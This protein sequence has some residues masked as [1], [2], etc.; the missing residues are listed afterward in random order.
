M[1]Y[2]TVKTKF[3]VKLTYRKQFELQA[4]RVLVACNNVALFMSL[5]F[6]TPFTWLVLQ[7]RH[8]LF[9]SSLRFGS[10]QTNLRVI[11]N[12]LLRS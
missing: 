1:S 3:Y 5:G 11:K 9:P 2:A 10:I 12:L 4:C 7:L 6:P 8:M